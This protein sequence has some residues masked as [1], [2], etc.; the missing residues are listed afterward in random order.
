M[1]TFNFALCLRVINYSMYLPNNST[2]DFLITG[3]FVK[4]EV[5]SCKEDFS[6]TQS[7]VSLAIFRGRDA[8]KEGKNP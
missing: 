5:K 8:H 3:R 1:I 6:L 7:F 4:V 2:N